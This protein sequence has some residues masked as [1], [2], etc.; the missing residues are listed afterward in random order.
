M[1]PPLPK[2]PLTQMDKKIAVKSFIGLTFAQAR[3]CL[4]RMRARVSWV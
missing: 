2:H 3:G 1:F 4:E